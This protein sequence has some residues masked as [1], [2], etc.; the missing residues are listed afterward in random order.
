MPA[1]A[2]KIGSFHAKVISHWT[3]LLGRTGALLNATVLTC[4][5]NGVC[6]RQPW[7]LVLFTF[8]SESDQDRVTLFHVIYLFWRGL[9]LIS[10]SKSKSHRHLIEKLLLVVFVFP[11]TATFSGSLLS[12]FVLT[13]KSGWTTCAWRTCCRA[14]SSSTLRGSCWR[15][16]ATR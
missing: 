4:V 10:L 6:T 14:I 16:S 5:E 2:V 12:G 9:S 7:N 3:S 11:V 8:P 15:P 1:A 13:M